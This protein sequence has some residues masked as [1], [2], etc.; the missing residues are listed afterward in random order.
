ME[1]GTAKDLMNLVQRTTDWN[2]LIDLVERIKKSR[3]VVE[4]ASGSRY[5]LGGATGK[6]QVIRAFRAKVC[7]YNRKR[8]I[9]E[10][11][12]S[13]FTGAVLAPGTPMYSRT[14]RLCGMRRY[15][16]TCREIVGRASFIH[17]I[18]GRRIMASSA[19]GK[20]LVRKCNI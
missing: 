14:L 9:D 2:V 19:T 13:V 18:S 16:S 10:S 20:R 6:T 17:P 12:R 11:I 4:T 15:Y 5:L 1:P 7:A 3:T 8:R